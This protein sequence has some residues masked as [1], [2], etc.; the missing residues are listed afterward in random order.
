MTVKWEI[1]V[2]LKILATECKESI[3][4][5]LCKKKIWFSLENRDKCGSWRRGV[6]PMVIDNKHQLN[7]YKSSIGIMR[8][9]IQFKDNL[10]KNIRTSASS[11][12]F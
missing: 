5:I 3:E 10:L 4:S 1:A 2:E 12:D 7:D 9:F 8:L 11:L 6:S